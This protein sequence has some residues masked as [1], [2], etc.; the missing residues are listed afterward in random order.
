MRANPPTVF[1]NKLK[2]YGW[3][4]GCPQWIKIDS[5]GQPVLSVTRD[6][7]EIVGGWLLQAA[8]IAEENERELRRRTEDRRD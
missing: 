8:R 3:F 2:M 5:D 6:E 1:V 4:D 7:A